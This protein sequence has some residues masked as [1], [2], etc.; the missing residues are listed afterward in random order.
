MKKA[1]FKKPISAILVIMIMASFTL[2]VFA[3]E[4]A[5]STQMISVTTSKY[6]GAGTTADPY[7]IITTGTAAGT[8]AYTAPSKFWGDS[9]QSNGVGIFAVTFEQYTGNTTAG[10]L[11]SSYTFD[12]GQDASSVWDGTWTYAFRFPAWTMFDTS[13][14][15][16]RMAFPYKGNFD[17]FWDDWSFKLDAVSLTSGLS[18]DKQVESGDT[19]SITYYGNYIYS[20]TNRGTNYVTNFSVTDQNASATYY[21]TVDQNGY[22][23]FSD[24]NAIEYGGNYLVEIVE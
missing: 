21:A 2:T 7:K 14:G 16:L 20:Q 5:I 13:T 12:L 17:T 18:Q 3:Y 1:I 24:A 9:S 4:T 19:I 23:T 8:G 11:I 22:A 6:A 15:D 10:D